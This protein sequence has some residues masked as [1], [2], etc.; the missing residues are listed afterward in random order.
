MSFNA[1]ARQVRNPDLSP[2]ARLSALRSCALRLAWLK[3]VRRSAV[4]GPLDAQFHFERDF[5]AG[6]PPPEPAALL[7]ALDAL[8]MERNRRL[9]MLRAF[10]LQRVRQKLR[11]C[12]PLSKTQQARLAAILRGPLDRE[13]GVIGGI[14]Q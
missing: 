11:G 4:L 14:D 3:H 6:D 5:R 7:A 9:D 2:W 10:A 8:T 1:Y 12:G 13:P